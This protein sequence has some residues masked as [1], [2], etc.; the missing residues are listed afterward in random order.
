VSDTNINLS[1][2]AGGTL[3]VGN[4]GTG[5][6]SISGVVKGNGS[7]A[8]TAA[9][10]GTDYAP[11]TS[12]S[13]ILKASGSGGFSNAVAGTDYVSPSSTETLT[14][15]TIDGT[16]NTII[17]A[18]GMLMPVQAHTRGNETFTISGGSVTQIA[19]TTIQNGTYTPAIGDRILIINA[20]AST[21]AGTQFGNTSQPANGVYVVTGNTTNISVSRAAD[22]SGS[23]SPA[24]LSV[25]SQQ[26]NGSAW[27][28]NTVWTVV[29]PAT[30]AA[31]TWGTTS[32]Q[33]ASTSGLSLS[34]QQ[35][36]I[37]SGGLLGFWN[38]TPSIS[39]YIQI[40]SA[41][42]GGSGDQY[43]T[44][45]AVLT[46]TLV[47]RTS[48][49]TLTNKTFGA[50]TTTVPPFTITS[51]TNLTTAA[52]GAVEYDGT[53]FSGT[54]DTTSGR[55]LNTLD[56]MFRLTADGSAIGATIADYFGS[57]SAFPYVGSGVYEIV[58]YL[59]YTKTTAGTVTY[60]LTST[61]APVNLSAFYYQS[62]VG[63]IGT[64]GTAQTAAISKSTATGAALPATG[65]LTTAVQHQAEIHAI[66]EANAS[67]GNVRLRV[68]ESSGTVTPLRGSFYRVRRLPSGNVGTFVA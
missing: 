51:G 8:M 43:L 2:Q 53:T 24:G 11:A 46:D 4:G 9:V 64:S 27:V 48:T 35:L 62:P 67:A 15:K 68:T 37:Q 17:K 58:W 52:A 3:P 6:T 21:G 20:N 42:P 41:T 32:I 22:M 50:G 19:G 23:V 38:N 33:F 7:S 61:N 18:T 40:N 34:P 66:Y 55:A 14:N 30:N 49:D 56:Q 25:Y 65:S 10:A 36:Y 12:G 13:S 26:T 5:A 63:G 31:F 29:A 28:P 1:E 54:I 47:S 44:L 45:P 57:N 59:W 39:T 60:T 16:G